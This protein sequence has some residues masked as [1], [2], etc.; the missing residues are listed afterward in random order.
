MLLSSGIAAKVAEKYDWIYLFHVKCLPKK[1]CLDWPLFTLQY[2]VNPALEI[3]T[4]Y[5]AIKGHWEKHHWYWGWE[6]ITR[7]GTARYIDWSWACRWHQLPS[8]EML[9]TRP[10]QCFIIRLKW[11]SIKIRWA[12]SNR[13]GYP[14]SGM[15]PSLYR[16]FGTL[17]LISIKTVGKTIAKMG[18][19]THWQTF[20][21]SSS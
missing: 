8:A 4:C 13:M 2:S 16:C 14:D 5:P 19:T 9:A 1:N 3:K 15:N 21:E 10:F 17:S 6:S 12:F 11:S 18:S 20:S 7:K